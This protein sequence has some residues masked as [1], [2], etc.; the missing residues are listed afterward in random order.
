MLFKNKVFALLL[1]LVLAIAPLSIFSFA[2]E[3]TQS[4]TLE[5]EGTVEE[6]SFKVVVPTDLAF[7]IDPFELTASATS[8][9]TNSQII[10]GDYKFLNK[11]IAPVK[12][13]FN[14]TMT[15]KNG[16]A[17]GV[18][19]VA[20]PSAELSPDDDTVTTK[21]AYL[22]VIGAKSVDDN[23]V[24]NPQY[25]ITSDGT[26]VPF[27][28][29]GKASTAFVLA[30]ST[31]GTNVA[32]GTVG[33]A[34]FTFYGV[35]NSYAKWEDKD[36][37]ISADYT[38]TALRPTTYTTLAGTAKGVNQLPAAVTAVGFTGALFNSANALE[39]KPFNISKAG[40]GD[41]TVPFYLG[42]GSG[43]LTV[44]GMTTGS[45]TAYTV[46]TDYTSTGGVITIKSARAATF[47][48]LAQDATTTTKITLS[49]GKTYI[50]N[51]KVTA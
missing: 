33:V 40:S 38:L 41:V 26:L 44:T 4:D 16:G 36:I 47:R 12:I 19:L 39:S 8:G 20:D 15:D 1:A 14:F 35:L 18:A 29:D 6:V 22:A 51:W 25:D 23:T 42:T 13:G 34:S 31:D 2:A 27:S 24:A 7:A 45:G 37:T 48:A 49:N 11:T 30:N 50:L 17:S 32:A 5:G 43:A 9:V 28:T 21:K 46:N 3:S 10:G